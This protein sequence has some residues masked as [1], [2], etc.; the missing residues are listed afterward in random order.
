M[1]NSASQKLN[2]VNRNIVNSC[3]RKNKQ[4]T[5]L[6]QKSAHL[7]SLYRTVQKA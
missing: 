1:H 7:T 4:E 5:Q 2:F 3:N 6:P